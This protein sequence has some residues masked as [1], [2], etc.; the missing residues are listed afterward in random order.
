V[1]TYELF[2]GHW[3]MVTDPSDQIAARLNAMPEYVAENGRSRGSYVILWR[4]MSL[5]ST[6]CHKLTILSQVRR[7]RLRVRP[8]A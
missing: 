4:K 8:D 5:D 7:V 1:D 3:P 6:F 2:V